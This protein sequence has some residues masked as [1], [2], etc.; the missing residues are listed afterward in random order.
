VCDWLVLF[1][2][3]PLNEARKEGRA[4]ISNVQIFSHLGS[5][6]AN[7]PHRPIPASTTQT[8]AA[9]AHINNI[10]QT[11]GYNGLNGQTVGYNGLNVEHT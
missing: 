2:F 9:D 6:N 11:V 5:D 4:S 1:W 8:I 3:Q 10:G 7:S